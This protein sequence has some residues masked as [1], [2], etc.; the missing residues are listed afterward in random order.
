MAKQIYVNLQ[1]NQNLSRGD[2]HCF[3]EPDILFYIPRVE[4]TPANKQQL[5]E[6]L[7]EN[8]KYYTR[9]QEHG[10]YGDAKS[11][12]RIYQ[13]DST[14]R[15]QDQLPIPDSQNNRNKYHTYKGVQ[16]DIYIKYD[17]SIRAHNC[18]ADIEKSR[19][20]PKEDRNNN[21][22]I[23][24]VVIENIREL[25]TSGQLEIILDLPPWFQE[26]MQRK[27]VS[28]GT[29][30][31]GTDLNSQNDSHPVQKIKH[32]TCRNLAGT[33]FDVKLT[34]NSSH[35]LNIPEM[36]S[37]SNSDSKLQFR[38]PQKHNIMA[39]TPDRI[40]KWK[41]IQNSNASLPEI[42]VQ[43]F[44]D[45]RNDLQSRLKDESED[46]KKDLLDN[47]DFISQINYYRKQLPMRLKSRQN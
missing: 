44:S 16:G 45:R 6:Q 31:D 26:N 4:E 39:V 22:T 15:M 41:Q 21:K 9:K 42:K 8:D 10:K 12:D 34:G 24:K 11:T 13:M 33:L 5:L 47:A 28:N 46:L 7:C 14:N 23:M 30:N 43:D 25:P 36:R 27:S 18:A 1:E 3:E 17:N 19:I 20:V 2:T 37:R 29:E 35:C 40:S 32:C 38:Q